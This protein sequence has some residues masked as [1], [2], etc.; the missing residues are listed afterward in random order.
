MGNKFYIVSYDLKTPGRDYATLYSTVKSVGDWQHPLESVW[1][2]W[3]P[4]DANELFNLIHPTMDVNDLLLIT[5][6]DPND[7]QGWL[8]KTCWE[9][10]NQRAQNV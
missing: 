6:I 2:V 8:P 1:I 4:K 10:M 3:T 9:W 7:R 5:K